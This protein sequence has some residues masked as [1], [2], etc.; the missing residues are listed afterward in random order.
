MGW[1]KPKQIFVDGGFSK[2][3]IYMS[4]LAET[5]FDKQVYASEIAQASALGAAL[6]IHEHWNSKPIPQQLIALKRYF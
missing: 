1:S 2:N 5:Y 3:D 4:L 6:V